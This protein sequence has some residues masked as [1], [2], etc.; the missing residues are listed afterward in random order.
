LHRGAVLH[1][2]D[3]GRILQDGYLRVIDADA[4]CR[5]VATVLPPSA[6]TA[7]GL[8]S[9]STYAM[10][11]ISPSCRWH[12][13]VTQNFQPMPSVVCGQHFQAPFIA[14]RE[15][16]IGPSARS[17]RPTLICIGV[18]G[19]HGYRPTDRVIAEIVDLWPFALA[20]MAPTE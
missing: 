2:N 9:G 19:S 1:W 20:N 7:S 11:A 10:T 16:R 13:F 18:A 3:I 12:R 14:G 5:C 6:Y 17:A 15:P 4:G 8:S